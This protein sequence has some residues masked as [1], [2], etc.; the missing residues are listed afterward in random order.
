MLCIINDVYVY[1]KEYNYKSRIRKK[2]TNE[3][4]FDLIITTTGDDLI[5]LT[6]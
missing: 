1:Y 5:I 3:W 2:T 6:K 4:F